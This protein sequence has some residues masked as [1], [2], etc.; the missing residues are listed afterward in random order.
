MTR[1]TSDGTKAR[2]VSSAN[3][4]ADPP[5]SR[6]DPA[7]HVSANVCLSNNQTNSENCLFDR[8]CRNSLFDLFE[9]T[10]PNKQFVQL[11]FSDHPEQTFGTFD[12]VISP[13]KH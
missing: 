6:E 4:H 5:I 2:L 8:N 10:K 11:L 12:M 13:V 9:T 1:K 7:N 3:G